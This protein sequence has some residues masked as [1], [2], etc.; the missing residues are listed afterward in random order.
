MRKS[1]FTLHDIDEVFTRSNLNFYRLSQILDISEHR[2]RNYLIGNGSN[3]TSEEALKIDTAIRM[4]KEMDLKRPD[5]EVGDWK[6]GI[7]WHDVVGVWNDEVK[8]LISKREQ[9][10]YDN[11]C[12]IIVFI[13][14]DK[15]GLDEFHKVEDPLMNGGLDRYGTDE[16]MRRMMEMITYMD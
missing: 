1:N 16:F 13:L 3:V 8:G 12:N 9:E 6:K 10:I 11:A 5:W 2:I 4:I 7:R 15:T 14:G